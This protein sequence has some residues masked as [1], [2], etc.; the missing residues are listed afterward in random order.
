M[1]KGRPSD[2]R[3]TQACPQS[4]LPHPNVVFEGAVEDVPPVAALAPP[5]AVM[6]EA[7]TATEFVP[8]VAGKGSLPQ[9]VAPSASSP[10]CAYPISS[11]AHIPF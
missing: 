8:P 7:V 2:H 5:D 10:L 3:C 1:P 6:T 11:P 4:Q 9:C